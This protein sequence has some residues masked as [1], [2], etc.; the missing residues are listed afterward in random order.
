MILT[1]VSLLNAIF[2]PGWP[3]V[4]LFV[5]LSLSYVALEIL[6]PQRKLPTKEELE[7]MLKASQH[8]TEEVKKL[9]ADLDSK[10][11]VTATKLAATRMNF[12][13]KD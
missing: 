8:E 4:T 5:A 2:T 9:V 12:G 11:K 13:L 1:T 3:S 7:L 6:L 10:I